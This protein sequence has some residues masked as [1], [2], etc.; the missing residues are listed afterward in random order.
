M[1][2]VLQNQSVCPFIRKVISGAV[3]YIKN[4]Q[5]RAGAIYESRCF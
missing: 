2:R 3:S 5:Y 1:E 4:N